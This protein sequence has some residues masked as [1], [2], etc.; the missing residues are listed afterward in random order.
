MNDAWKNPGFTDITP[1]MR[2]A[3]FNLGINLLS[4]SFTQWND[5]VMRLRK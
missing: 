5:A 1:Q 3:A 2:D 4:Y